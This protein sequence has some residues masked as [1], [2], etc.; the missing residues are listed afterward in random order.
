MDKLLFQP[1]MMQLWIKS[2]IEVFVVVSVVFMLWKFIE[3]IINN[4]TDALGK[5]VQTLVKHDSDAATQAQYHRAEHVK[6]IEALDDIRM[7]N[8]G[9][10]QISKD[11][12]ECLQ[13]ARD[14]LCRAAKEMRE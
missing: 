10:M 2:G 7:K 14:E 8:H 5:I 9:Q 1:E 12:V 4:W 6:M 3:A 11:A 13:A